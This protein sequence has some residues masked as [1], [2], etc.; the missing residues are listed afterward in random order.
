MYDP[1]SGSVDG[2]MFAFGTRRGCERTWLVSKAERELLSATVLALPWPLLLLKSLDERVTQ[3]GV[4]HASRTALMYDFVHD[5]P[6]GYE[7][8]LGAGRFGLSE[9]QKP[10]LANAE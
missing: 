8:A 2:R 6:T 10:R 7:T 1:K 4:E 3:E 9:G 5:L